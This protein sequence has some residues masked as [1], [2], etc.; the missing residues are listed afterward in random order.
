MLLSNLGIKTLGLGLSSLS[1]NSV[2]GVGAGDCGWD[3]VKVEPKTG[4][5]VENVHSPPHEYRICIINTDKSNAPG[6]L[7]FID[8][9][10]VLNVVSSIY[11]SSYKRK[12]LQESKDVLDWDQCI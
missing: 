4:V 5:G 1:I 7:F 6:L 2:F 9:E 10:D 12:I 8:L 11:I 3:G